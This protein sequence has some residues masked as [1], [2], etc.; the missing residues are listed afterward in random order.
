MIN[1]NLTPISTELNNW[2][3]THPG[4]RN[5]CIWESDSQ[6][7]Q[8]G[9]PLLPPPV[10]SVYSPGAWGA[11]TEQKSLSSTFWLSLGKFYVFSAIYV[12]SENTVLFL[13]ECKKRKLRKYDI[14]EYWS[15]LS[16]NND[17]LIGI[18]MFYV[19]FNLFYI[20]FIYIS[21]KTSIKLK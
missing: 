12:W 21:S 14:E 13:S 2:T 11:T 18:L 19:L 8:L 16:Q 3:L 9:P 6:N 17:Y 20:Y 4:A 5:Y 1:N 15:K 10:K 7:L